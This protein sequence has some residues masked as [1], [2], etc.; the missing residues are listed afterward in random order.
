M[1]FLWL[2]RSTIVPET[3]NKT[4][5]TKGPIKIEIPRFIAD[6]V[7]RKRNNPNAKLNMLLPNSTINAIIPTLTS[8]ALLVFRKSLIIIPFIVKIYF[9]DNLVIFQL[10]RNANKI[11]FNDKINIIINKKPF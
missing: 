10:F 1:I 11:Y 7:L 5:D 9:C 4:N 6:P 2:K 8:C 3:G